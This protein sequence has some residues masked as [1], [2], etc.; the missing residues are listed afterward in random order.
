[1]RVRQ[2]LGFQRENARVF[3]VRPSGAVLDAGDMT[4]RTF[5]PDR[6]LEAMLAAVQRRLDSGEAFHPLRMGPVTVDSNAAARTALEWIATQYPPCAVCGERV[7]FA[8]AVIDDRGRLHRRCADGS[9]GGAEG[10]AP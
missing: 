1:M 5:D 4:R 8:E 2:S 7:P 3:H 6:E 10:H 9:G